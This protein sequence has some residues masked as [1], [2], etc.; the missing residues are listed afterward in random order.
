[1]IELVAWSAYALFGLF[2]LAA[3]AHG[4]VRYLRA[5]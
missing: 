4:L 3:V 1:M 2:A 5:S